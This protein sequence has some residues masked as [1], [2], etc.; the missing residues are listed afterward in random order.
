[1]QGW[2]V[3]DPEALSQMNIPAE[4]TALEIPH[5]MIQFFR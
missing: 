3:T 4:E 2:H 1:V 5:R